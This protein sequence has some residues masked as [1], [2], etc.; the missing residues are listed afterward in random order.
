MGH[1]RTSHVGIVRCHWCGAA[2]LAHFH[3]PCV[4]EVSS[5]HLYRAIWPSQ[6]LVGGLEH[7]FYFFHILGIFGNNHHPSW[8]THIFQRGRVG[9]PP[10]SQVLFPQ[11]WNI[12]HHALKHHSPR[13]VYLSQ[14]KNQANGDHYFAAVR[15]GWLMLVTGWIIAVHL[16]YSLSRTVKPDFFCLSQS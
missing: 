4:L 11:F 10:T 14:L 1:H 7:E 5:H 3:C 13:P 9:I 8:R 15:M 2:I 16:K 6:V 12:I